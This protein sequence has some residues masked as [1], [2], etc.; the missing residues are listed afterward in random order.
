M[1]AKKNIILIIILVST[2]QF[3]FSEIKKH[4]ISSTVDTNIVLPPAWTFGILYGGYT[5]QNQTIERIKQI[6]KHNYPIDAYWIDSWFWSFADKGS[7]PK[8]Y[9]DFVADT[10]D[11]PNRKALWSFMEKHNIKGGF[12]VWD[13]IF[14]K[15]NEAAFQDFNAKGFFRNKYTEYNLGTTTV[16]P[17]Q[18]FKPK[19]NEKERCAETSILIIQK[20]WLI[21][22]KK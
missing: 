6:Q 7:G 16:Q 11:F 18:C 22:K 4:T 3:I 12:W 2:F 21:L 8:K 14:E 15:G 19:A 13:C 10:V 20:Q 17:L 9:I 1:Y 5:N